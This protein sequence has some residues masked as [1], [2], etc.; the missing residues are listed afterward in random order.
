MGIAK[1]TIASLI[2]VLFGAQ[3]ATATANATMLMPNGCK[4]DV[5]L[6]I[7]GRIGKT[8]NKSDN[9]YQM[10]EEEF[11]A[12][13]V[14][15]V[16]TSTPWTPKSDFVGPLLGKILEEVQAKGSK[17]RLVALDD[18]SAEVDSDNLGKYGTILAT[19]KDGVRLTVRDFGPIFVMFP[20]DSFKKELD[21]PIGA[22]QMVW[23]LCGIEVE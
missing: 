2:A 1:R 3:L 11:L 16:T 4:K 12:L 17:L 13:P 22:S 5:F 21:T 18:F 14:S 20:R 9:S 19:S 6:T 15:T 10:S 7:S 23:Q 8:T